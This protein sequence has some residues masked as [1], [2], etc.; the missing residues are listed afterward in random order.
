MP[1]RTLLIGNDGGN[2]LQGG[3]GAELIYGF[4]PQGPQ[5]NASISA[6]RIATGLTQPLFCCAPPGDAAQLFVVEKGGII[7]IID[8]ATGATLAQPF[9]NLSTEVNTV[10]EQGLLGL[11]FHPQFTANGLFYVYL[12]TPTGDT[13]V[14]R[15]QVSSSIANIADPATRQTVAMFDYSSTTT[16][17]R[18]GWLAFGPE[19]YLYVALGDGAADPA[20][21]QRLD[22][23]RGKI[24]RID[25]N[26][27]AFP[28]DPNRNYSVPGDNPDLISGIPG[29]ASASGIYA[30]GLRN[31]FRNSFDRGIGDFFIGDVGSVSFE[32][33][34]RGQAGAN[35]GWP[36]TEGVFDQDAFPNFT[37]PI[38]S[39]PHGAGAS[40]T[41]GYVYRGPG[42]G[43]HGQYFFAD[44]VTGQ[45][46]TMRFPPAGGVVITER[47][48]Q[49]IPNV[50]QINNP[51]SFG[52]DALG[53]LYVVDLDGDLFRLTPQTSSADLGDLLLGGGGDDM[54]FGGG[55]NDNLWGGSGS[56]SLDGGTGW[57]IARY[58]YSPAEV[59]ARLYNVLLN[60]SE[61]A[62]DTYSGI[63]GLV[64]S[65]LNDTLYG[66]G[67]VNVLY[68]QGG[69]D[70]LDGVGSGDYLF[71][72]DGHD[73]IVSRDGGDILDGGSGWDNVRYDYATTGVGAFLYS[74]SQNSGWAAGDTYSGIEGLVGSALND[75]LYG[76]GNVNVLYGQ[77]GEDW[78]D[79]VG[80]GDYL[81]GG[82]GHDNIVSRDGGDILDG[83]SGWD[84]VRYDY[85]TLA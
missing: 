35:Y 51:A 70:W 46:W 41:G 82:D 21:A 24:L 78:L 56:D 26:A 30:A 64:G 33:I 55:G 44:F 83:G 16:N 62:G 50:G 15:Y 68:G 34:N 13:E 53:N 17:H 67:N 38:Y 7:K 49:I 32:E 48:S 73:N 47:T 11:A 72:G 60:T 65:A 12:S 54:I 10:G 3:A 5:A 39:Y 19:G 57:D 76:D 52:E 69:E 6:T 84:N 80:G 63:E 29:D 75:T 37:Q 43:L 58:D 14:R 45:I 61:A 4:N 18:A 71:G 42:E 81:F 74:A 22:N 25:V 28:G 9:L 23:S 59:D 40:V 31:P 20:S 66:D 8:L 77:G 1:N 2:T 27:D 79:G 36:A 85:A